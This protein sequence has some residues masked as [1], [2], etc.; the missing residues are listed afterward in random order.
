MYDKQREKQEKI[1]KH[2]RKYRYITTQLLN[3]LFYEHQLTIHQTPVKC[4]VDVCF[5]ADNHTYDIEVKTRNKNI[6]KYPYVELKH[7]KYHN[8]LL[9]HKNDTLIY[10]VVVN[11]ET[12]YFFNLSKMKMDELQSDKIQIKKVEYLEDSELE[13][14][15]IFQ[16]PISKAVVKVPVKQYIERYAI[17]EKRN[18]KNTISKKATQPDC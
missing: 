2:E 8:M 15:D 11:K 13:I 7:S 4:H 10:M 5:T 1:D 16:I 3:D 12:A 9:D 17:L 18:K 6:N 14:V